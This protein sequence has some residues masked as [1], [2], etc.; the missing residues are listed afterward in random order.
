MSINLYEST[1]RPGDLAQLVG[2]NHKHYIIRL[3]PGE[4]FQSHRGVIQHDQMIGLPWGSQI[5]SHNGSP[6]FLL[7]PALGSL[8]QSTR[9]N[10]QILYPKDIGFILITMGIG[11]GKHVLEAG[12]GSGSLTTA[13]AYMV[14]P[15]GKVTSYEIRPEIQKLAKSNLERVGLI[16]RVTFKEGDIANGF[17]ETGVDA[18][19]LDVPNP[20]DYVTQVRTA[21]KPGG[22]FGCILPTMNQVA[23]LLSALRHAQFAFMDVCEVLLRFYKPEPERLR[24]VDRMVAHTGYL[25]F[26]RPI[27]P[28]EDGRGN[29]LLEEVGEGPEAEINP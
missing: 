4:V 27:I 24:P 12:T 20:F 18:V 23:Y 17:E 3:G 8:I 25:I 21:L 15:E 13:F 6:F 26:A 1:A 7:Q 22:F 5:F 19:F 11:P 2:L 16:D 9:R 10:T 14:G 29:E 28:A